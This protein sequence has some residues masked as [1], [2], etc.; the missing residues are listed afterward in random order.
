MRIPE[1][2]KSVRE[3]GCGDV[4]CIRNGDFTIVK[5][6]GADGWRFELWKLTEQLKVN[7]RSQQ[8]AIKAWEGATRT[9]SS[10]AASL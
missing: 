2:W 4:Y 9:S 3:K 8:A 5:I 10:T 7:L 1:G 6:G